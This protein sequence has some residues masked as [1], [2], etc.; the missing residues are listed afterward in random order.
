[1]R[2]FCKKRKERETRVNLNSFGQDSLLDNHVERRRDDDDDGPL[3]AA[4]V[5]S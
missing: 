5:R 1:M 4:A 2:T 3:S